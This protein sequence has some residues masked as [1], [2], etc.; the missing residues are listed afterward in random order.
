MNSSF[1]NGVLLTEFSDHFASLM[2]IM[3]D[4]EFR[5][6][7]RLSYYRDW[8]KLED[9]NFISRLLVTMLKINFN[10]LSDVDIALNN[11]LHTIVSTIDAIYAL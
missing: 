1:V 10:D 11:L 2:R 6:L 5:E 8:S 7:N 3:V 9:G 4:T